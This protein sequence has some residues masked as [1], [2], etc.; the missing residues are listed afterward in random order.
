MGFVPR[1]RLTVLQKSLL[2]RATISEKMLHFVMRA[3]LVKMMR[4][5]CT[6][7]SDNIKHTLGILVTDIRCFLPQLLPDERVVYIM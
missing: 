6:L 2:E 7:G 1:G 5:N 3:I 4:M